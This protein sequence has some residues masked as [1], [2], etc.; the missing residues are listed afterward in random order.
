MK[1]WIYTRSMIN[2]QKLAIKNQWV[3]LI[4]LTAISTAAIAQWT[5]QSPVPTFLDVRGIAAPTAQRVFIA[6]DDNSFD[7]GGA[8]FE[9]NDGGATWVQRDIPESLSNPFNG[10]FF[11]DNL[12]GWVY[13]NENYRTVDGGTTWTPMPFL[14]ST[15]FMEFYTGT[16][17]LATGNFGAYISLDGGET[18]N[19]SPND[20]SAFDFADNLIGL[21]ASDS[22]IF[23]TSNGG[24]TFTAVYDGSA[25]DVA[26]L[27]GTVAV[28]IVDSTFVRSTNGGN[29]WTGGENAENRTE[30]LAVSSSVVLALGRAGNWPD[31]DDRVFR[32]GD[33]G[34]TWTD[35]GEVVPDGIFSVTAV[36]AQTI[37]ALDFSGNVFRSSNAG[38][39]WA[40][41]FNSPGPQPGYLGNPLPSFATEQTGYI[42]FGPGFIIK[43]TDGGASWTQIS[44]GTGVS[45]L[46]IDRF[47][48]GNLVAVGESGTLLT[49]DGVTAWILRE[50]FSPYNIRAVDVVSGNNVVAVDE[51]GQVF[52]SQ[53]GGVNWSQTNST[54]ANLPLAEDIQFTS[55]LDGWVIGQG[56]MDGALYHTTDGGDTWAPVTD[57]M[58][59][60][61]AVDVQGTKVW[62]AN[63][64][65]LYYYSSDNGGSWSMGELPGSPHQVQDM[66]FYNESVGY[67]VGWWGEV[68]RSN[69]G[70]ETWNLVPTPDNS[71]NFTDICLLGEDEL[72]LSTSN[73]LAYYSATGGQNWSV[74]DIGSQG[75]GY[76]SAI[77]AIPGGDVLTVGYQG[78]IEHFQG[79]IP[80]PLN[81]PPVAAFSFVASGLDVNF[82]D[83]STDPD[84]EIISWEWDFGDGN[85][86]TIQ[87]PSHT[88]DTANTYIVSLTVTDNDDTTSTAVQFIVVQPGPGGVFG[89]FTEI[90]PLDS[91]FVTPQDEDFWVITTAPADFDSDGDLD[92]AVLGYYVV[93][94]ESVED[95]L[96]LMRND[97]QGVGEEWAFTYV[98]VPLGDL[99]TGSSDMAWGDYDN[100]GDLDLTV[101]TDDMTVLFDNTAGTLAMTDTFLPAYWEEN[102][103]AYFDLRSITWADY[104]NDSDL[105][106]LLPSVWNDTAF[107]YQTSLLRNDGSNG[108]GGWNFTET[109]PV[110][111]PTEHAQSAWADYDNDQD[112]DLFLVN[113]SPMMEDGFIRRYRNDSNGVFTPEDILGSLTVEHGEAQW[114]DYD[115]DGDLDILVAGNVRELDGTYSPMALRIYRNDSEVYTTLDV[116]E[117][118]TC[119][120]WFDITAATWADYDAD[121]DMDILLAG[122][123]NS[124]NEIEGRARVYI[125]T[126]NVFTDSGNELPAPTASGDRGGTFSWLDID[127]DGDLDY[128][129]AGQYF[130]PG[131]NGLVEAQMHLYRNDTPGQNAAPSSPM[132]QNVVQISENTA[133]LTWLAGSDDHTPL[134]ALT[135]DLELYRDNLPVSFP[136]RTPEPGNVSAVNEWL[137]T[138][139]EMGDYTWTL[140]TVDAAYTGSPVAVGE[141]TMGFVSTEE[142]P[143]NITDHD[144]ILKNYPNPFKNSTTISYSIPEDGRVELKI[145]NLAGVEVEILV[146]K[147]QAAGNHTI[148]YD[149]KDLNEGIYFYRIQAGNFSKTNKMIITGN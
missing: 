57:F 68:F 115:S 60:Y 100:D 91:L 89:D 50:K 74:L 90:T 131:G 26:F 116:I 126:D 110:F 81:Q 22:A 98:N 84:G 25:S 7:Q 14:G 1:K 43:T 28:A 8:L 77:T 56:Y 108:S 78:Y 95:R 118:L 66:E 23:R 69:D 127:G 10:I 96:I 52:I 88:Y 138:G 104:D 80:P 94:N 75:L 15:Y 123:Y 45:L 76:F 51:G 128:F 114:G 59:A 103:Q 137:L 143:D 71:I 125:N 41:A 12:N 30:L 97:G 111:A 134:A 36:D 121:G 2:F 18:W 61:V 3:L 65:G 31:Y 147:Y 67:A 48:N 145:Y 9:S 79:T 44:S 135:Y 119:E 37:V 142:K 148:E 24:T 140:R 40:E 72:W 13:G 132:P 141:F 144:G 106:L 70:G 109:E 47:S 55:L 117:C 39:T 38:L 34:Q 102:S 27:S 87:N 86:S 92:I 53:N 32:S 107:S 124:G 113:I 146:D 129:I 101:G 17:G 6:T 136:Q 62:A 46:D 112:L 35:L 42:G 33:G 122:N 19:P 5:T 21:G 11:L 139:L 4:I 58:G 54:P 63:V 29:N 85:G 64:T 73:D 120:G 99:T 16:F 133:L 49:G 105:D 149:A 82:T 130:V 93:Y 83:I 20:I